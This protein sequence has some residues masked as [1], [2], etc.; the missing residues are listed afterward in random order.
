M[1][2]LWDAANVFGTREGLD[3]DSLTTGSPLA[4][5]P[6][7]DMISNDPV[8]CGVKVFLA[9]DASISIDTIKILLHIIDAMQ[10][11]IIMQY[12][13]CMFNNMTVS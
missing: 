1:F 10:I 9:K 7:I 8:L 2:S 13:K 4:E 3:G 6:L 11:H 12:P 5:P